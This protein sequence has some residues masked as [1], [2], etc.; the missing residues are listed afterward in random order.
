MLQTLHSLPP[1][2]RIFIIAGTILTLSVLV[3]V[4]LSTPVGGVY[5][6][7]VSSG[8]NTSDIISRLK[9]EGIIRNV[10]L[11]EWTLKSSDLKDAAFRPGIYNLS[12]VTSYSE[13]IKRLM[14]N[15]FMV[16]NLVTVS[17]EPVGAACSYGGKTV[18]SG[19]DVNNND[20]LDPDEIVSTNYVCN[21]ETGAQGA[22]G[23]L[24][25]TGATG[26]QGAIGP[27]GA[28]GATGATGVQGA[29]GPLGATGAQGAAGGL[30]GATGA[31]G[32]IGPTGT[33]GA[34]GA[35]GVIGPT[36]T[37]GATGGQ[38]ITGAK[39]EAGITGTAGPSGSTLITGTTATSAA[40]AM[41]GTQ[42][43]STATCPNG[44][45]LLGGGGDIIT[46]DNKKARAVLVSS[47]P[48]STTVWAAVGMVADSKLGTQET[49]SVTAYAL[50]SL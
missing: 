20:T 21:G 33:T 14:N 4:Y 35:Q 8:E 43:A 24:G 18:E 46:T 39:G 38:G 17:E 30:T 11:F 47:R 12:G 15:E 49:I 19:I 26:A 22:I 48:V 1:L 2:H 29:I 7:T 23:P 25:A 37:T 10:V 45:I 16:Q 32:V 44:R 34:T 40:G 27:T 41:K 13:I 42:V 9:S 28:T 31:Q 50:C 3:G 5:G 6:F 36:G